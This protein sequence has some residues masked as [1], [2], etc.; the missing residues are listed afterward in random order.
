MIC[1]LDSTSILYKVDQMMGEES[2]KELTSPKGEEEPEH[3]EVSAIGLHD[4]LH[5]GPGLKE[6]WQKGMKALHVLS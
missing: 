3:S 1:C 4:Q 2:L 5:N 6:T